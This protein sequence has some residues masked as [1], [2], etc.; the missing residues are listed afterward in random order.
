MK[1]NLKVSLGAVVL[2]LATLTAMIFA[3]LNFVQRT[4]FESPDDGIVWLDTPQGVQARRVA[5]NSPAAVAGVRT[6]DHLLAIDGT[7]VA[8]QVQ[9][10]KRLWRAGLWTKVRYKLLR[11]G[12]TFETPL[13]TA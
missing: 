2:A 12:E 7:P 3:W 9:V 10:T 4:E 13:V 6:G 5:Q 8:R 11:N 1:Q